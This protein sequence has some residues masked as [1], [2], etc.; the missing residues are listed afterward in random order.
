MKKP[1]AALSFDADDLW[2]YQRSQGRAEWVS[3]STF[4]PAAIPR[5]LDLTGSLS[6]RGTVFIVGQD[7]AVPAHRP[8]LERIMAAGHEI[9]NHSHSH[10]PSLLKSNRETIIREVETAERAIASVTG[11]IP[12]GFRGPSYVWTPEI[13]QILADRGY[14]YDSS[15]WPTWIGPML[16]FYL[17][18]HRLF[19]RTVEADFGRWTEAFRSLA[20]HPLSLPNG[21][22]LLEIP[23]TTHPALRL[24]LHM[25]YL[26]SLGALSREWMLRY[27][28]SALR[29]CRE[30][31]LGFCFLLHA[32]DILDSKDMPGLDV[33]P[34]RHL[35]LSQKLD[36]V[37]RVLDAIS[38]FFRLMPLESYAREI[39]LLE[40]SGRPVGADIDRSIPLQG[41]SR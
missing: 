6:V 18:S 29:L 32:P 24:P 36:I 21:K 17:R 27:L 40:A 25:T 33:L 9:G 41:E 23:V 20:P 22:R 13:C 35:P 10:N 26:L 12:Q 2:T 16:K 37:T 3:H 15:I 19:G 28:R 7:A 14:L 31:G 1:A 38:S 11:K 5:L 39:R 30:R 8:L 34:H 4:W